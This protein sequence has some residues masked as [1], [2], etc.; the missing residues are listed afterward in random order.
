MAVHRRVRPQIADSPW[1]LQ[2]LAGRENRASC[3]PGGLLCFPAGAS[4]FFSSRWYR[5]RMSRIAPAMQS[6]SCFTSYLPSC[7]IDQILAAK[8]GVNDQTS[9]RL[10]LQRDMLRADH[11]LRKLHVCKRTVPKK[12]YA[13]YR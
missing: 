4:F 6:A 3:R 11:E 8:Y 9:Y 10:A 13:K 7:Q 5:L 1:R 2:G 12:W